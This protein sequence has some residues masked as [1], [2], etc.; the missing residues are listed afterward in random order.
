[1]E[2]PFAL[3]QLSLEDNPLL[4]RGLAEQCLVGVSSRA[5]VAVTAVSLALNAEASTVP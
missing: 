3:Q 2:H 1:M 4:L 5:A